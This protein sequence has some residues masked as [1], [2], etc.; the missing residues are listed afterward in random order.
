MEPPCT[1][2]ILLIA[3]ESEDE[4]RP[5]IYTNAQTRCVQE[6]MVK[7]IVQRKKVSRNSNIIKEL[8]R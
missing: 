1:E 8:V 5:P 7:I 2:K 6:W 4:K 3:M